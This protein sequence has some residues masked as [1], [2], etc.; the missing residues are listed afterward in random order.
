MGKE[1]HMCQMKDKNK[2]LEEELNKMETSKLP[3][4]EFKALIRIKDA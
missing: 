3:E 1:K 4:A 2:V